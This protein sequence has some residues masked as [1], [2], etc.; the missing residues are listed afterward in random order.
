MTVFITR[1]MR[2]FW[3]KD[4]YIYIAGRPTRATRPRKEDVVN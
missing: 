3:L 2:M 1:R 4:P